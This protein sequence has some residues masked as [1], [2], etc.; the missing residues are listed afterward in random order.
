MGRKKLQMEEKVCA[1]TLQ[2]K[3]DFVIAVDRDIGVSR[4]AI[5]SI[6]KG[7]SFI[8]NRDG[9]EEEV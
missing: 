1:L 2:E 5:L 3:G 7:S 9:I 8:T 4:E 6:E